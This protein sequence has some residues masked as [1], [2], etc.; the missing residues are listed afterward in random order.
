MPTRNKAPAPKP[1]AVAATPAPIALGRNVQ[2]E[3]I[4]EGADATLIL[5]INISDQ[6]QKAGKMSD[7]GNL[8]FST[9]GG[10]KF[11]NDAISNK[12]IGVALNVMVKPAR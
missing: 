9:T 8:V 7:K 12:D 2:Y 6:A 5:M 10:F 11:F 3:V 1:V 4:G